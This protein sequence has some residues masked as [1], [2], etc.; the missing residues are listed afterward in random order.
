MADKELRELERLAKL[1]DEVATEKLRVL[2]GYDAFK[3][4]VSASQ[5]EAFRRCRRFWWLKQVARLP[6]AQKDYYDFG[7]AL[8]SVIERYLDA[9]DNGRDAFGNPVDLY[10]DGWTLDEKSGRPLVDA[11]Q[12]DLIK[13]LITKAIDGG[14]LQRLPGRVVEREFWMPVFEDDPHRAGAMG[15][16][17]IYLPDAAH[18]NKTLK[19][20]RY[21]ASPKELKTLPQMLIYAKFVFEESDRRGKPLQEVKLRHN[22]FCK[23][24]LTPIVRKTDASVT[25]A[26]V[27]TF[28]RGLQD[29]VAE[30][31][32]LKKNFTK[33]E[34]WA[35]LPDPAKPEE[36]CRAYGGCPYLELC[37]GVE[38]LQT[39]TNRVLTY[40]KKN[41]KILQ[42]QQDPK[43]EENMPSVFEKRLAEQRA[44]QQATDK[45]AEVGIKVLPKET[46]APPINTPVNNTPAAATTAPAVKG[47]PPWARAGC[48][49]CKGTGWKSRGFG[50][51]VVCDSKQT[52]EGKATSHMYHIEGPTNGRVVYAIRE[53]H[54]DTAIKNGWPID[55]ECQLGGEVKVQEREEDAAAKEAAAKKNAEEKA[56]IQARVD[57]KVAAEK[58]E[59]DK[60]AAD[61][62]AA[63]ANGNGNGNGTTATETEK[64]PR[65]RRTKAEIEAENGKAFEG[66]ILV[67]RGTV[68][69]Y[70]KTLDLSAVLMGIG[71]EIAKELDAPSFFACHEWKRKD[72]L[73]QKAEHIAS[74]LDG[75]FVVSNEETQDIKCLSSAL[76]PLANFVIEGHGI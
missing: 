7:T 20:M 31:E 58:A 14:I 39:Y 35:K 62:A 71:P 30:M 50:A 66:F 53:E 41:A 76:A 69:G 44:Q 73:S 49:A 32:K 61:A 12:A 65:K 2:A 75:H 26:E 36:A 4:V 72:A 29:N 27:E 24:P 42:V 21:A 74:L 5:I 55:G 15:Y 51:C 40:N 70:E 22:Q 54:A 18:D 68:A 46:S 28:W 6:Q 64:K 45:A 63:A 10:P 59:A 43:P 23:D 8:H 52:G 34:E 25:R 3:I 17:D 19:D 9:D 11:A 1:G 60:K 38:N 33:P 16:I 13:R 48:V 67:R 56:A 57:A 37:A 47:A